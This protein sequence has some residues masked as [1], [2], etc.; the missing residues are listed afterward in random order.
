MKNWVKGFSCVLLLSMMFDLGSFA[1]EFESEGDLTS[2][3]L[4]ESGVLEGLESFLGDTFQLGFHEDDNS[5]IKDGNK[6]LSGEYTGNISEY[7]GVIE[8]NLSVLEKYVKEDVF[9][10][11]L[12]KVRETSSHS[13]DYLSYA[14]INPTFEKE[15]TIYT[16][17]MII[18]NYH[19]YEIKCSK[20][21]LISYKYNGMSYEEWVELSSK[22]VKL[23][24]ISV[25]LSLFGNDESMY[26]DFINSFKPYLRLNFLG[27]FRVSGMITRFFVVC[28]SV[29]YS[30]TVDLSTKEVKCNKTT[31]T[32]GEAYIELEKDGIEWG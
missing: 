12:G 14:L 25:V 28:D 22:S 7:I 26:N 30:C 29:V 5:V 32:I 2:Q 3:I 8:T 23:S 31:K 9:I 1:E 10:E 15:D 4:E 13:K 20:E 17:Y 24:E 18:D 16:F 27:N 21:E 11:I 6:V 19:V